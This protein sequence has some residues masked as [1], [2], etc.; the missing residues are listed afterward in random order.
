M[1]I[2]MEKDKKISV[3]RQITVFLTSV[4]LELWYVGGVTE[5]A[6]GL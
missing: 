6:F 5:M 1:V 4:P 2:K 3:V